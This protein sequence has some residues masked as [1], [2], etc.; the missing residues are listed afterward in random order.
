M[1]RRQF[2]AAGAA[3]L[4]GLAWDRR[5]L[6]A[7][8][9]NVLLILIDDLGWKDLGCYGGALYETPHTDQLAREGLRFTQ[10]YANCPVCSPSRAALMTG[11]NPAR[12]GFTGHIT[13]IGRHRWPE[14]GR[15]IPPQ[16]RMYLPHEEVTIAEVLKAKGY[17]TASVGKWHLGHEGY[18]PEDQGFDVN[19]GGWTHGSPPTYYYP[20]ENPEKD[21]NARIPTLKPGPEGQYLTDRLTDEAIAFVREHRKQPFF[22]YLTYYAVHT[23]LEAPGGLEEKYRAKFAGKE[24]GIHPAYAA[25]VENMDRNVGRVLDTLKELDL[26]EETF[27]VFTSDN[28]GLE[29]S[30]VQTP[31][32]EGK[33]TLYEGGIRV[34]L[35]VRWP[36]HVPAGAVTDQISMGTDLLPTIDAVTGADEPAAETI[37]GY[38]LS[39]LW[40][41]AAE[42]DRKPQVWYYPHYHE[43]AKRPGVA[44]RKGRYKLIETYDPVDVELYDLEADLS[45]S[46]N[47]AEQ[48][49][50][51]VS[52]LRAE[53][54]AYLEGVC[55][56]RHTLN[57]GF[58]G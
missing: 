49:P 10:A 40:R 23:P 24:T 52:E 32:R 54:N 9:P 36:G 27:V 57:P 15:I 34:P 12:L 11:K 50:E 44:I 43:R 51:K 25:M 22:L 56:V 14:K 30:G 18:W 53:L 13:A 58:E 7:R 21:W 37:D 47:L 29:T 8:K 20:Y 31:L 28:G 38:D 35:I 42:I 45:E 39:P 3:A 6:A 5:A 19:I 16:D 1:N 26:E 2:L 33:G 48:M 41:G 4:G 17:A 46:A 55:E